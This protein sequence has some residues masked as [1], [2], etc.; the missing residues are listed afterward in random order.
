MK[1][2]SIFPNLIRKYVSPDEL[3]LLK[4]VVGYG[5]ATQVESGIDLREVN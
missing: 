3:D 4:K 1:K 2:N 5:D